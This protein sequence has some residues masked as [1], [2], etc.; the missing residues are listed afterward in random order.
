MVKFYR[1]VHNEVQKIYIQKSTWVM[2]ILLAL[3]VLVGAI[4]NLTTD[5]VVKDYDENNWR[6][7]L[8]AENTE[9]MEEIEEIG[10]LGDINTSLIE[11]NNYY[12]EHDIQPPGYGAWQ[13][14]LENV[15]LV[16]LISLFT[17]IVAAGILANEFKWGTIKLILIRPISR[18]KILLSKYVAVLLFAIYTL[19]FLVIFSVI[20][21]ALFFGIDGLNPYMVVEKASGLEYAPIIKEVAVGYGL[22]VVNLVMMATFAFMIS[23]IFRSSGIAIGTAVFLM[24]AGNSIVL[25]FAEHSWS[26]YIL[27]ANTDLSQYLN[28]SEPFIE[29]MSL[30]FSSIV[31]GIY[32]A[33]F[34]IASW[35]VFTKRDVA[36]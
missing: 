34:I 19:I 27:F 21:G 29:G 9:L 4:I 14:V 13:Y 30:T 7:E 33:I 28:G 35:L 23:S 26:K 12:L 11:Q 22:K 36:S 20:V 5:L 8:Q 6:E 2:Y 32:F 16:S 18:A 3:I 10:L 24:L 15:F 1:L 25:F 17:I 31:L